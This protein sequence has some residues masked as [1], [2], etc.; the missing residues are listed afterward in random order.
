MKRRPGLTGEIP[1]DISL[2]SG[3]HTGWDTMRGTWLLGI[4]PGRYYS[5]PHS[6]GDEPAGMNPQTKGGGQWQATATPGAHWPGTAR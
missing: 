3:F 4:V 2:T 5:G 6:G 1:P